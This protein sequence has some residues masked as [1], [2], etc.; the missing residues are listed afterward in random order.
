MAEYIERDKAVQVALE[1]CVEVCK[2]ITGHGITQIHAVEIAEKIESIPAADAVE[3][4]RC[5]DCVHA[6][7]HKYSPVFFKCD[8]CS[9][10]KGRLVS[11]NFYCKCGERRT[12]E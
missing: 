4:V 3:V 1:A 9:F 12:E 7:E 6:V 10:L 8:G 2:D 5:K 11:S